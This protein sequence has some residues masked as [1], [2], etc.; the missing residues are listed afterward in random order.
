MA[1]AG[2]TRFTQGKTVIEL[3][4]LGHPVRC[5]IAGLSICRAGGVAPGLIS[6]QPHPSTK[7]Q[8]PLT[9]Q[10]PSREARV[11]QPS[12]LTGLY[13]SHIS[14]EKQQVK[15]VSW[16][17]NTGEGEKETSRRR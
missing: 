14:A 9:C 3:P 4:G 10:K 12:P 6:E 15:S 17:L 8:Y 2:A 7:P 1:V 5:P 13:K 16:Y 11:G